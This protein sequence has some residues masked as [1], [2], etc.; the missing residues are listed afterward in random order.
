MLEPESEIYIFSDSQNNLKAVLFHE[1]V[2]IVALCRDP[3]LFKVGYDQITYEPTGGFVRVRASNVQAVQGINP[4]L[5]CIDELHLQRTDPVWH[6][7][8][9]HLA[10][11]RGAGR[12]R[13]CKYV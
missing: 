8:I 6:G 3:K 4:T 1:L 10:I 5:C 13:V 9:H 7:A 11:G 12:E 2:S